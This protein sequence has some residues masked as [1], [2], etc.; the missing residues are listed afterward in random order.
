MLPP[1]EVQVI[2]EANG[3]VT[4]GNGFGRLPTTVRLQLAL[5]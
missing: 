5:A 1:G 4:A 2:S 3:A